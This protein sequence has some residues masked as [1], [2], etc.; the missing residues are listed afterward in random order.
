MFVCVCGMYMCLC[1]NVSVCEYVCVFVSV[2]VCV[3]LCDGL[4]MLS[5]G[6]GTIRSF[7]PFGVDVALLE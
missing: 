6:S 4:Y 1:V 2:S 3:C 5:P 7:D